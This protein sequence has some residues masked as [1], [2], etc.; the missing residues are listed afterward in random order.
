MGRLFKAVYFAGVVGEIV[1]RMPY[2]RQRR[3]IAKVDQRIPRSERAMFAGLSLGML[4]L[5]LIYGLTPWLDRADYRWSA[6]A[7]TRAGRL[8]CGLLAAALW[9][10]WRSHRDLGA[11]WSP[12]LEIGERQSLVT[13]GVYRRVRH[14]MYASQLLWGLAQALLLPNR[15]AGWA[16]LAAFVPLYRSRV[17]SEERMMEDHFGADY[18]AYCQRTGRLLPRLR[19]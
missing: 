3:Q 4:G 11:N 13:R 9:L 12:T 14:P 7:R 5:P 10:F 16:S 18:R 15:I 19:G 1:L 8:G 6:A 17:P 2:E